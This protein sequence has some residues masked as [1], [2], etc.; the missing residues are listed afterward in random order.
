[1]LEAAGF[2]GIL[3]SWPRWPEGMER[4]RQEVLPRLKQA[5]LR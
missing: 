1:M 5:Q 3:L 2:D 4:F